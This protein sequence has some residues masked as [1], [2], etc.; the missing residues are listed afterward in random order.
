VAEDR[1]SHKGLAFNTCANA[2]CHN[3]HDNTALYENYLHKHSSDQAFLTDAR[4]PSRRIQQWLAK[5]PAPA[6]NRLTAKDADA[7]PQFNTQEAVADWVTSGHAMAGVNCSGCHIAADQNHQDAAADNWI[8]KP[9]HQTC[10]RCH[11]KEVDGFMQGHHGMRLSVD[12]NPLTV[13]QAHLPMHASAGHK[14]LDCN[15]CHSAHDPNLQ[16]A[17]F[18][19]CISCHDDQ[20]SR[21]YAASSHHELWNKEVTGTAPAGSGVSCATCH[22]PRDEEGYVQHNQNDNLRPNEKMARTVC[23]NC[24]GL[25]FTLNALAEPQLKTNCYSTSPTVTIKSFDMVNDWFESKKK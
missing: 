8:A 3:Y 14:Q 6:V 20:H 22:M 5:T 24:H 2:G 11:D 12:L 23:M 7:P 21:S 18:D 25:P 13:D 10:K 9:D 4:N 16:M 19:A 15:A 1:P 17:A